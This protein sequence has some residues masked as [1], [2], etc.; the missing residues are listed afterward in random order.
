MNGLE[1]YVP[2]AHRVTAL[3]LLPRVQLRL[4]LGT[5]TVEQETNKGAESGPL[6]K[7]HVTGAGPGYDLD[8]WVLI[9]TNKVD[10]RYV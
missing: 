6:V 10:L 4:R 7:Y 1:I 2:S 9:D 8:M 5:V 3:Y